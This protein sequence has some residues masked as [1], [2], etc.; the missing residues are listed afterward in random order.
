MRPR[1]VAG[2]PG[3]RITVRTMLSQEYRI[4]VPPRLAPKAQL[5]E[6]AQPSWTSTRRVVRS[7]A[8]PWNR[9]A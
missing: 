7:R 4:R 5:G 2:V 6:A 9:P 1:G 3:W 8:W